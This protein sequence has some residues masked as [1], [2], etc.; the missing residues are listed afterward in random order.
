MQGKGGKM[1]ERPVIIVD[2]DGFAKFCDNR[3]NNT[4]CKKHLSQMRGYYGGAKISKL[5]ETSDC[6]GYISKRKKKGQQA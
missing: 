5:R 4:K 2:T 6:E 3:C 1:I